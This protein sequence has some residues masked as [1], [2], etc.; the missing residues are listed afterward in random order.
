MAMLIFTAI[1]VVS[2]FVAAPVLNGFWIVLGLA[3]LIG[4]MALIQ[5]LPAYR[6]FATALFLA[7]VFFFFLYPR[8]AAWFGGS[9]PL[10]SAALQ[11]RQQYADN[12]SAELTDIEAQRAKIGL[13]AFCRR[14]D[15]LQS[16]WVNR[17]LAE[18]Q[19][20]LEPPPPPVFWRR[21]LGA[22]T[23]SAPSPFLDKD[24]RGVV[25]RLAD[26]IPVIAQYREEC[27]RAALPA[28]SGAKLS[29]QLKGWPE[30]IADWFTANPRLVFWVVV[31]QLLAA[32]VVAAVMGQVRVWPAAKT[33]A[34][35]VLAAL[36]AN[37]LIW[38]GGWKPTRSGGVAG[39]YEVVTRVAPGR[40]ENL[41]RHVPAGAR[42]DV[43]PNEGKV[44]LVRGRTG[45]PE[46]IEGRG[47]QFEWK[48]P[49][50]LTGD[51]EVSIWVRPK[52]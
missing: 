29:E 44:W 5:K 7:V 33:G 15:I 41:A 2:A 4:A 50:V 18:L 11:Q 39:G 8:F 26:L 14:I 28:E 9:W 1:A 45:K 16:G 21:W 20:P 47:K 38:G 40:Q 3:A 22:E 23:P 17:Q 37:W 36:I 19:R 49:M 32:L 42:W 46:P 35:L 43:S 27:R 24:V 13:L 12:V 6:K 10:T 25:Q 30:R 31:A 52:R 48:D 51:G 34:I